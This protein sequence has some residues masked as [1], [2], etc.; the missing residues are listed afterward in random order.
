MLG[1]D[2]AVRAAEEIALY[3]GVSPLFIGVTVIAVGTSIPEMTT[4]MFASY[5]GAGD[6]VVGNIV[7]SEVAQITLGIGVV[8]LVAPL[9][10]ARSS[11]RFYGTAMIAAMGVM[12]LALSDAV[13]VLWEG[14]AMGGIYT[15]FLYALYARERVDL[16][17]PQDRPPR[18]KWAV[19]WV[20]AGVAMVLVGGHVMVTYGVEVARVVG[21]PAYVVG[22]L[23]GLGTTA[24]EIVVAAIASHRGQGGIG[25]GA[26]LGSNITD[27]VLSLGLGGVV[28]PVHVADPAGLLLSVTYMVAVAVFVL[29]LLYW[30]EG[31]PRWA[32]AVCVALYAPAFVLL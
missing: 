22:L 13:L 31:M 23:T 15:L 28:A 24:P 11:T 19:A 26:L 2:R 12:I 5:Y 6:I 16:P 9:V 27:P 32:G 4:S 14:A 30:R 17:L 29:A 7:G 1:A 20:L 8:A 21:I 25:V 18:P 10:A 3:F